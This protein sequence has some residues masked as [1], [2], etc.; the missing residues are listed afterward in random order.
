MD[1]NTVLDQIQ[2]TWDYQ[3]KV[4]N[5]FLDCIPD[6][7]WNFSH[8]KKFNTLA[9]QYSHMVCVYGVYIDA[10]KNQKV[11]FSKKK[12]FYNGPL[13]KSPIKKAL[14]EMDQKFT[15]E[16]RNLLNKDLDKYTIDFFGQQMGIIE[17]SHVMI[18]HECV[19]MGICAN[20]AAFG[21]F[22]TPKSWQNDWVL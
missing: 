17:F 13:E 20:Y 15:I 3:R 22:E 2:N 21:E 4:T 12:S 16:L 11:D 5:D 18:Q 9:K 8:H 7:K 19:H 14:L 1:K 6:D 10:I